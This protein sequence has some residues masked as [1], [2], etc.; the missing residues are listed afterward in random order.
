M[1]KKIRGVKVPKSILGH[2]LRKGTRKDIADLVRTLG[3]PDA[4]S[5]LLAA[6]AALGPF[7]ADRVAR[8]GRKLK[9]V[10]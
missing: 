5:L 8:K 7:L 9:T 2:K 4:R 1:A 10:A 6:A 3:H